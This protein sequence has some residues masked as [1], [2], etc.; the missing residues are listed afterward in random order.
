[1]ICSEFIYTSWKGGGG[2]AAF[3]KSDDIT[4]EEYSELTQKLV[5]SKPAAL[6]DR[7]TESEIRTL[8]PKNS[9][10]F[11]LKSGRYC[12]AQ[13]A[14]VGKDYA[15]DVNPRWGNYVIHA[16]LFDSPDGELAAMSLGSELFK[17]GL[18]DEEREYGS[19]V[20]PPPREITS[21]FAKDH[22][23]DA[24]RAVFDKG[25]DEDF[26]TFLQAVLDRC[27]GTSRIL[28]GIGDVD[29]IMRWIKAMTLVLPRTV[30][31]LATFG[32]YLL[33]KDD[34]YLINFI[35]NYSSFDAEGELRRCPDDAVLFFDS[36]VIHG[37]SPLCEYLAEYREC[38]GNNPKAAFRLKQDIDRILDADPEAGLS[39]AVKIR[40]YLNRNVRFFDE[41]DPFRKLTLYILEH[42]DAY[43]RASETAMYM[44]KNSF[45]GD[46]E[47][48]SLFF[49][50]DVFLRLEKE[51]QESVRQDFF[52]RCFTDSSNAADF[53]SR[54]EGN[55]LVTGEYSPLNYGFFYSFIQGRGA[56]AQK[57]IRYIVEL[58]ETR[59]SEFDDT[60][61]T[62]YLNV[63]KVFF[64]GLVKSGKYDA[65]VRCIRRMQAREN[66]A[67][68]AAETI[69]GV[70]EQGICPFDD[71]NFDLAVLELV[72][73][74]RDLYW[75][76]F[77][78]VLTG[79][80][81]NKE[82]YRR[83]VE[84]YTEVMLNTGREPDIEQYAKK[85]GFESFLCVLEYKCFTMNRNR[86][87]YDFARVFNSLFGEGRPYH[88]KT[89]LRREY[90]A[91]LSEY[92]ENL[93]SA[94]Q[95]QDEM[96][97]LTAWLAEMSVLVSMIVPDGAD[98]AMVAWLT[99]QFEK[100]ITV[101]E[102]AELSDVGARIVF[103]R[104]WRA[105]T[106]NVREY[107]LLV[108]YLDVICVSGPESREKH[109]PYYLKDMD[110]IFGRLP[111]KYFISSVNA[112][113]RA[114]LGDMSLTRRDCERYI[115]PLMLC[116]DGRYKSKVY[117]AVADSFEY[118]VEKG[119]IEPL[120]WAVDYYISKLPRKGDAGVAAE[121]IEESLIFPMLE[122]TRKQLSALMDEN[123]KQ[124]E[125]KCPQVLYYMD[126][127]S[128][129]MLNKPKRTRS[130][131]IK[132]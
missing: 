116:K 76:L 92:F 2:Y 22:A 75:R 35:Y 106:E 39:H 14:Y 21:E 115:S 16:F 72:S 24:L 113:I 26:F 50:G 52:A 95:G 99:G 127:I 33:Y 27:G 5:Y 96:A 45:F 114:L 12:M 104:G 73:H 87:A 85:Y 65:A 9:V 19:I 64:I 98:G 49:I 38:Y 93:R 89:E 11:R 107:V 110:G 23:A 71:L 56:D 20:V 43:P 83:F 84:I 108:R 69:K 130:L 59:Y 129:N 66:G 6:P 58:E 63:A 60:L 42:K 41:L 67:G 81:S 122:R 70:L 10:Y 46:E 25:E 94:P 118:A 48:R 51:E 29:K 31:D 30:A 82:S 112:V 32:T 62:G 77:R 91:C 13:S 47:K 55:P 3:A 17:Q 109:P 126:G 8:F 37:R 111:E 102:L 101:E 15:M 119:N 44:I 40:H 125:K 88:G 120:V 4:A 1:M 28:A 61:K 131:K 124:Y 54:Y 34:S 123:K 132:K 80:Q 68:I 36:G 18:T 79:L 100:S 53:V 86:R 121:K 57:A 7:P 97:G 74:D 78:A 105:F 103:I 128:F 117:D 90:Y